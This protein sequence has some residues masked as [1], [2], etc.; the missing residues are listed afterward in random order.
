VNLDPAVVILAVGCLVA[1][2]CALVGSFLVL[3]KMAMLGDAISHS[4]LPGIAIAFLF[5]ASRSS[6]PMVIGAGALG[7]LTVFLVERLQRTGRLREDAT[8]GVVFP[9]L[10][11][12]G[13]VLISRYASMVDLDLD[14]VLHGEIAYT[15]WD[16]IVVGGTNLGPRALWINGTVFL[17]NVAL[18]AVF[19]KEL[20]LTSFDPGLAAAL[21][22]HPTRMHYLLMAAVSMTVVASFES[23]GAILVVALLV[24]PPATAY[25]LTNRLGIMIAASVAMGLASVGIGYGAA[26]LADFSIAGGMATA[27][28]GLFLLALL[29]SPAHGLVARAIRR[30]R[31]GVRLDGG[32][33]LLHLDGGGRPLREA[34]VQ[35]RLGWGAD[36]M[37]RVLRSL[38][39]AGLVDRTEAGLRLTADGTAVLETR[40]AGLA[41]HPDGT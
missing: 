22:F 20:K 8:I 18:V 39:R 35:E 24:V 37:G 7:V 31:M 25:L 6:I 28:G 10:F 41:G 4:V 32:L 38:V 11:A 14:C 33:L 21:G 16:V 30:R 19:Y 27:A 9:F 29:L 5:T 26:R 17:F 2:S 1:A 34:V 36:R 15:P 3:R 13:V 12:I 40:L 23:V